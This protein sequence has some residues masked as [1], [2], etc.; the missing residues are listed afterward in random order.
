ML[1]FQRWSLLE[2]QA[3]LG[4][5]GFANYSRILGDPIF[6]SAARVSVTITGVSVALQLILG[7]AIA[8]MLRTPSVIQRIARTLLILPMVIAPVAAGNTW[9]LMLDSSSGPINYALSWIG[10]TGPDWLADPH[11]A[12]VSLILVDTWQWTPF[13]MLI[14]GAGMLAIPGEL[15]EAARV[16]GAN[17]WQTFIR[18][19][20]PLLTTVLLLVATFR[21]LDSLLSLDTVYSLTL[22]GPGYSTYTLTYYL[23]SLGLRTFA[24]GDA[25][26]GSWL[27]MVLVAAIIILMFRLN[28]RSVRE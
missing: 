22:G 3:P 6:W 27:F 19:E 15:R 26:A 4:F 5:D 13:V 10:I 28:R 18:I 24:F 20:L 8:Y 9:R 25:S 11:W 21:I 23:Y 16:D 12:V 14:V 17:R 7:T 1:S 2:S